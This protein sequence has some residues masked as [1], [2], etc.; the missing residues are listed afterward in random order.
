MQN[1]WKKGFFFCVS[2]LI[3]VSESNLSCCMEIDLANALGLF[4]WQ[5]DQVAS[6]KM[7]SRASKALAQQWQQWSSTEQA[8]EREC[9]RVQKTTNG[10]SSYLTS[11]QSDWQKDRHRVIWK[12]F[13]LLCYRVAL[14]A[15]SLSFS[16][17][18]FDY[19]TVAPTK[20]TEMNLLASNLQ[21]HFHRRAVTLANISDF[22]YS[23]ASGKFRRGRGRS[24]EFFKLSFTAV[25]WYIV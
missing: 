10:G 5:F 4:Q 23:T 25:W 9:S 11:G 21:K 12:K 24:T 15:C 2:C 7:C 17:I 14:H 16:T 22:F 18:Y 20:H 19:G 1:L 13:M 6:T 8:R 3:K